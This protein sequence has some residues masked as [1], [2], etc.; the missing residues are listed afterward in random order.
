MN[1]LYIFYQKN[2]EITKSNEI[3]VAKN[4][5][6][7][8]K[9]HEVPPLEIHITGKNKIKPK[10]LHD[11]DFVLTH[12]SKEELP[13]EDNKKSQR[14]SKNE[15]I[16]LETKKPIIKLPKNKT[17]ESF[18]NCLINLQKEEAK[19]EKKIL[20]LDKEIRKSKNKFNFSLIEF[21]RYHLKKIFNRELNHKEKIFYKA[22]KTFDK[23]VDLVKI[24]K[25]IHDIEKLKLILFD[26]NQ[27]TM[28]NFLTKPTI[29]ASEV[30]TLG[31]GRECLSFSKNVITH[32]QK[33][34]KT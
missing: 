17:I 1:N 18:S 8:V 24:L 23:E 29:Y 12:Y 3:N 9:K 28:F 13:I 15:I 30:D 22:K 25:K 31:L 14:N 21:F 20:N 2:K 11:D 10:H 33:K 19:K 7:F 6:V 32:Q 34:Q 27:L 4:L 16:I 26:E 5:E